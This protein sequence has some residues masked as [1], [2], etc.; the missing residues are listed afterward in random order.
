VDAGLLEVRNV[1]YRTF[2]EL[3]RVLLSRVPGSASEGC[4]VGLAMH[5]STSAPG[6]ATVTACGGPVANGAPIDT[7]TLGSH[8]FTV[9]ALD[10][11][12]ATA[13]QSAGYTVV[14]I[15]TPIVAIGT[16]II[17]G[18]SETAKTWRESNKLAHVSV[19]KKRTPIGT[20]FSFRLN[21]RATVTL[22]FTHRSTGRK[23]HAKCVAPSANNRHKPRCMR[24][25]LAGSLTFT[26]HPGTNKVHFAGR[27]SHT[28]ELKPGRYTL[29]ITATNTQGQR[30]APRT[31]TFRIV[32]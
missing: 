22:S 24:T 1:T 31:L 25:I 2:V 30:S 28:H 27:I 23:V 12:G 13:T 15:G 29:E 21:E 9:N 26:G 7:S 3:G 32:K 17:S 8:T 18:A 6:G 10:S 4:T 20:T 5:W 14:A 11:D 19:K 16:P